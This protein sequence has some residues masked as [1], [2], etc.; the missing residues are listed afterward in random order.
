[1]MYNIFNVVFLNFIFTYNRPIEHNIQFLL[2]F[3]MS[4]SQSLLCVHNLI[5]QQVNI[6]FSVI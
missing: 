1:M 3:K 2:Q 4:I 6:S 5:F